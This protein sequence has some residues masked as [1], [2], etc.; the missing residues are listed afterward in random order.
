MWN[1]RLTPHKRETQCCFEETF[2]SL[3]EGLLFLLFA[4][5]G[6]KLF[7]DSFMPDPGFVSGFIGVGI[8]KTI[9]QILDSIEIAVRCREELA[10]LKDL[11]M[12]I[13]PSIKEIQQ[14]RLDFNKR[15]K[16]NNKEF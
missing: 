16:N 7:K 2:N 9:D 14:H 10:S 13:E 6:G 15:T 5:R 3:R 12:R 1:S 11:V 8:S 4:K